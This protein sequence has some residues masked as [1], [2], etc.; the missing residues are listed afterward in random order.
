MST[1]PHCRSAG[2]WTPVLALAGAA[3]TLSAC[4]A[5]APAPVR[6]DAYPDR[7]A[8]TQLSAPADGHDWTGAELLA[9]ALRNNPAVAEAAAKYRTA[10]AAAKVSHVPPPASLTLTAEYAK[11]EPKQWLYG[12]T[13]DIPL[14]IGGR[15]QTRID[16]ADLAALQ[17]L[18]DYGEAVWTIRT[19]LAKART[20]RAFADAEV[21]QAREV[22]VVRQTRADRLDRRVA[23]GEDDR[24][25]ALTARGELETA[26]RRV[27]DAQSRRAAA[28]AAMAGALGVPVLAVRDLRLAPAT[29]MPN[30]L[31]VPAAARAAALTRRDVLRAVVDYDLAEGALRLEIAKQYPE[32]RI[33]PGYT[34][35]HG[36][37][38]LPFNL[39][40]TL[41]PQDLNRAAIAQAE[42]KRAEAG[43]SLE[44]VQAAALTAVDAAE[45]AT[46]AARV[47]A[48]QVQSRD[49]PNADALAATTAR[50]L[51]A[52]AADRVDDL[53][54]RALALETRLTLLDA[55][56]AQALAEIDLEDALRA[57]FDPAELILL[58]TT[59]RTLGD[60]Q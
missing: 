56:K 18:Y 36:V 4:V 47:A 3:L 2:Q 40:L 43:R 10:R 29:T 58:E 31:D 12:A 44:A 21:A 49:I 9:E 26:R 41:P 1:P 23:A 32:V 46:T 16:A 24:S 33:G 50:S 37:A 8:A 11:S 48:N 5:Y 7:R 30:T 38:K 42:A 15:R 27:S 28:D 14:D 17:A 13:S 54:A 6:L 55:R 53:G 39:A 25:L 52:G 35:D 22:E 57:P 19:A 45:A 34:Y 59:S 60:G 51:A 20:E